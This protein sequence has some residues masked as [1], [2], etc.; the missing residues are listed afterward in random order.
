[1]PKWTP[2]D[3][4]LAWHEV[5]QDPC[6]ERNAPLDRA[7]LPALRA[8]GRLSDSELY[9]LIHEKF[10]QADPPAPL[11]LARVQTW[12]DCAWR[13]G[14]VDRQDLDGVSW[15]SLTNDGVRRFSETSMPRHMLLL[16]RASPA[17]YIAGSAC[18]VVA[19]GVVV[20]SSATE[21]VGIFITVLGV[22]LLLSGIAALVLYNLADRDV[23]PVEARRAELESGEP[24]P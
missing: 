10:E 20:W 11:D 14:L 12:L 16:S 18:V 3:L 13:R 8:R 23:A 5:G 21:A 2:K 4:R 7:F 6:T 1:M 19:G 17:V 24:G 22:L 9:E 15:W